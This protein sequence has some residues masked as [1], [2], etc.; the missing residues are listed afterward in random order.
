M[1][2]GAMQISAQQVKELRERTG[3]GMMECKKALTQTKGDVEAAIDLLRSTGA[4][5][6]AK[7]SGREANEGAIGSYVHM[8]GRIGVLIEVNCET[9]FVARND[10]FQSLV[11]D[12]AMHIAAASPLAIDPD[13]VPQD[14]VERERGVFREQVRAEGKPEKLW[15]KIVEGKLKKFYQESTLL[16]QQYVR[17][18]DIT[19]REY[20]QE[21]AA[22]TGENIVVRRFARFAIGE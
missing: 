14:V 19:I 20:I 22:K 18:P 3:A 10:Q 1:G 12:L 15:D 11:R 6:A 7:R 9:D 21:A 17:N 16:E 4:A 2:K 5:K 8:G 13:S